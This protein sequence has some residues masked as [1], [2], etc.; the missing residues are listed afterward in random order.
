MRRLRNCNITTVAPTGTIS[1]FAG[2]SSGIEPLFAVAFMRN[3]A[4]VMMPDVNPDFVRL[5]QEQ[6][7]YSEDLMERIAAEGHIHF[8][9]VPE[10]LQRV[11]VTAHDITPEWHVRMQAAYQEHV[12]SAIS[13]TCNFPHEA[14]E[15]EVRDIYLLAFD[16]GCKGVTVY[17]DGSRPMQVLST[18]KTSK[19]ERRP[20]DLVHLNE[21]ATRVAELEHLLADSR[22]DAH[23]LRV[24]L[25]EGERER[26]EQDQSRAAGRH[27]RQRPPMLRGR[28]V[29]TNSP[30]GDLYVTINEDEQ[31]RPFEVFCTL[32]KAGG[33][34]MADAEAIGRLVSLALRS[35]IPITAVRDQLRGISCDRA[36]GLGPNKV[37]SAPDA[38]GQAIERYLEEKEGVQ[39]TLPLEVRTV[40][41]TRVQTQN[42]AGGVGGSE[43]FLGTCPDCASGHLAYLEGCVKCHIC[44]YSECG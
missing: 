18:G 11:F 40:A 2:C 25:A 19:G 29:K 10:A 14:T 9:E 22:E 32:G 20:E 44:G 4:G 39:E 43:S 16:L 15:A 3:Q 12:D 17:R 13:K 5:A 42:E 6:G 35:G 34:A 1:I 30:L 8:D 26:L 37:L 23:G 21:M 31:G 28:T 36:V 41:G 38:I 27:K 7:W 33:A 24:R